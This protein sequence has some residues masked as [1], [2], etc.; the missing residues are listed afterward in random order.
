MKETQI[1]SLSNKNKIP[2]LDIFFTIKWNI[3]IGYI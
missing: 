2:Q 1:E 3:E